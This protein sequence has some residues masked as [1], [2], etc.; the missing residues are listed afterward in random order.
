MSRSIRNLLLV[1]IQ[2][3]AFSFVFGQNPTDSPKTDSTSGD[4]K[5]GAELDV[6]PFAT[7]GY[8]GSVFVGDAWRLRAVAA[9]SA[10]PSFLVTSSFEKKRT[11][12]YALLA[13]RFIGS[14]RAKMEGLWVGGGGEFW[15][16]RIRQEHTTAMTY[17]NNFLLTGGVGYVY[18]LSNHFYVNP[19]GAAHMVVAGDRKINVSGR[20]YTQPRF[21]PEVSV[22]LGFVF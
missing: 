11:D 18:K 9:R 22:K 1:L 8:Y 10:I 15:R 4:V 5:V 17:Y 16:S 7:G 3:T 12:A 14:R 19:W 13:D 6:L 2:I 21:T 20:T